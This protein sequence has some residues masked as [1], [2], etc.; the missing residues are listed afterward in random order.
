MTT[1]QYREVLRPFEASGTL[2]TA[3]DIIDV[4]SWK[5]TAKLITMRYLS[6]TLSKGVEPTDE[7]KTRATPAK[8]AVVAT[9][10]T[11]A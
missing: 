10:K 9:T 4:S 5:H 3:G 2:L 8:K 11:K 6:P 1:Q 7:N